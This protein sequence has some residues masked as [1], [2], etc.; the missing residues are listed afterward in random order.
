VVQVYVKDIISSF[1]TPEK[2]L[3]AFKKVN[4]KKGETK[5]IVFDLGNE[6][7]ELLK[8]NGKFEIEEGRFKIMVGSSS[9]N[10]PLEQEIEINK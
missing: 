5:N 8:E 6:A 9:D 4:I 3:R 2:Q 10:T 1:T 7:F